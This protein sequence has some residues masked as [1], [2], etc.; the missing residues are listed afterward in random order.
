MKNILLLKD[1]NNY[2]SD[3]MQK[4]R[5]ESQLMVS[6]L[7]LENPN[8]F[9]YGSTPYSTFKSLYDTIERKPKRF[10]VVGSSIGW[11]NFYWNDLHPTIETIGIALHRLRSDFGKSLI[12]KYNLKNI[13]FYN[14]DYRDFEFSDGDLIWQSNLCFPQEEVEKANSDI[15]EKIPNVSIISYRPITSNQE[16]NKYIKKSKHSVS[17]TPNQTFFVYEKI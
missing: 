13:S 10:I 3:N 2:Y 1:L 6:E 12:N 17:W 4:D 5:A 11:I 7:D 16:I 14:K 9:A 8:L 15:I